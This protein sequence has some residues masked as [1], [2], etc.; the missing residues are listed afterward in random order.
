MNNADG[1]IVDREARERHSMVVRK[2]LR[3]VIDLFL[4]RL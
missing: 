4:T 2:A 1:R 3:T